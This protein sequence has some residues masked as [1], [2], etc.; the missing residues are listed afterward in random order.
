MEVNRQYA[1]DKNGC[2][3]CT[4]KPVPFRQDC[5]ISIQN[6]DCHIINPNGIGTKYQSNMI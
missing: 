1:Y 2:K 4:S 6:M 3:P 5:D